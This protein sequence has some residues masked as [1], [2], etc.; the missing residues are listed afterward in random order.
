MAD[1]MAGAHGKIYMNHAEYLYDSQ[2]NAENL[3]DERSAAMRP[4]GLT[5][6]M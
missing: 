3:D 5:G 1:L 6:R 2:N 4:R